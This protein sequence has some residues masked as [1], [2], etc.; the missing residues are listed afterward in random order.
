M[1]YTTQSSSGA[2]FTLKGTVLYIY[3]IILYIVYYYYI[4]IYTAVLDGFIIGLYSKSTGDVC[5]F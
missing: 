2:N 3:D 5:K 4:Y 1:F